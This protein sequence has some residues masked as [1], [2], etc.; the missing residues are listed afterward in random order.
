MVEVD[1]SLEGLDF[2]DIVKYLLYANTM[3]DE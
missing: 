3:V 1:K 2:R